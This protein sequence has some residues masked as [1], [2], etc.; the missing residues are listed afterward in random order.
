MILYHYYNR[1]TKDYIIV[2]NRQEV[3]YEGKIVYKNGKLP[4]DMCQH[5]PDSGCLYGIGISQRVRLWKAYKNNIAQSAL[6]STRLSSGKMIA[7]G[8]G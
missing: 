6:R 7:L 5:Y 8:N 1:T 2:I 3:L 4:F